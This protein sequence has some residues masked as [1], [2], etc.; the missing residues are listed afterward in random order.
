MDELKNGL[1]VDK[2]GDKKWYKNGKLHREDG[3]AIEYANGH[4]AWYKDHELHREDGP[5]IEEAD[6]SRMWSRY[7]KTHRI[8]GPAIELADG[9]KEFWING[10]FIRREVA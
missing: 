5:A 1:V 10:D 4:R 6:G 2:W 7:G 9:Y 8:D 3:P